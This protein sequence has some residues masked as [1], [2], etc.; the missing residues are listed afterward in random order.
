MPDQFSFY[1]FII[2]K[3][4]TQPSLHY[5]TNIIHI[6][7]YIFIYFQRFRFFNHRAVPRSQPDVQI[8]SGCRKG[9]VQSDCSGIT[10]VTEC[11]HMAM[12]EHIPPWNLRDHYSYEYCL[13]KQL[14]KTEVAIL[15]PILRITKNGIKYT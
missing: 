6:L 7:N 3:L 2:T 4:V 10:D 8:D 13:K 15:V 11:G 5:I 1:M 9:Y 12:M 14:I